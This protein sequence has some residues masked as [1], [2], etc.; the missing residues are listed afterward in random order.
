M[1]AAGREISAPG[2][3]DRLRPPWWAWLLLFA[4]ATALLSIGVT[5]D[6]RLVHEDNGALHTTFARGHLDLGLARTR[7]H[8]VFHMPATG[9]TSVYGHHPP[10]V[11]LTLAAAF[12]LT[13]SDAPWVAR[14]VMIAFQL[15]SLALMIALLRLHFAPALAL[16]GGFV[17]ATVPMSAFFGRMVNYEPPCLAG[18]LLALYG[19]ARWHADGSRAGFALLALG[20]FAGG[21]FDWPVFFFAATLGLADALG[22]LRGEPGAW[23]RFVAVAAVACAVLALDL[24]HMALAAGTLDA[25]LEVAGSG[26]QESVVVTPVSFL[27]RELTYWRRFFG[28]GAVLVS[29]LAMLALWWPRAPLGGT[30]RA[31]RHPVVLARWLGA[32]A[33]A[34]AAYALAAPSWAMVHAYWSFY[35]L[36]V[37]VVAVVLAIATLMPR[38]APSVPAPARLLAALLL[39]ALLL[40]LGITSARTLVKR[41]STPE[42]YALRRTRELREQYLPP[43]SLDAA[44]RDAA[45]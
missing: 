24:A 33:A 32:S 45:R 41:H 25:L 20:I 11:S 40:D 17:F 8:D 29:V 44:T 3:L 7:G 34:A 43:R 31:A 19:W 27:D 2:A 28:R 26:R 35:F 9:E 1:L 18:V 23:R 13:G 14:A 42:E 39:A 37:V 6:W 30:L 16:V 21:L 22:A 12:A 4:W 15:A 36:P 38:L 10:G 5:R